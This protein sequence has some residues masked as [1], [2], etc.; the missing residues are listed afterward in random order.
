MTKI[1][2]EFN[3]KYDDTLLNYLLNNIKGKSKNNVKSLLTKGSVFVNDKVITKHDYSLKNGDKIVVKLVN[4]DDNIDILHED[5]DIIVVNKPNGL[6]TIGTEREKERTLYKKVMNYLKRSNNKV[7][8]VHRLDKDTSGIVVFAKNEKTKMILQNNWNDI[9]TKRGYVAVV[10]GVV[11][12]YKGKIESYLKENKSFYVYSTK[13][14]TNGKKAVTL[15]EKI[16]SNNNYSLLKINLK[17]GRK[18]QIRVHMKDINHP[19]VG[20]VKYGLNT[21]PLKRLGLHSNELEF[22]H[23]ITKK[24][25]HFE[26]DIPKSFINITK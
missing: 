3:I 25:Y 2:Y 15:Y 8:V 24:V 19:V 1:K 18:N 14:K 12:K 22:I 5:E 23:P 20:D 7:F 17:T 13:D 11:E 9:V 21:N 16:S 4:I 26:I 6:L 10:E